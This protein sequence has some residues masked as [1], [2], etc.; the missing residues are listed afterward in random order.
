[1]LRRRKAV[2]RDGTSQGLNDLARQIVNSVEFGELME[3]PDA[4]AELA[5]LYEQYKEAYAK[6]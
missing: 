5:S 1:M 4:P 3:S 2:Q 6:W